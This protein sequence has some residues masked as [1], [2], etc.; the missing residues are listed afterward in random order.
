[1]AQS[2]TADEKL[3]FV[4]NLLTTLDDVCFDDKSNCIQGSLGKRSILSFDE[5]EKQLESFDIDTSDNDSIRNILV[6]PLTST[7]I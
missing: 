6:I 3:D 4:V 5:I 7:N 1:M 2:K